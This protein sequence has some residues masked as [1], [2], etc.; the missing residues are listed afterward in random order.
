MTQTLSLVANKLLNNDPM[1]TEIYFLEYGLEDLLD[2]MTENTFK[3]NDMV[4]LLYCF[5]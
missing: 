3:R 4:F 5:V 1:Q 2:I